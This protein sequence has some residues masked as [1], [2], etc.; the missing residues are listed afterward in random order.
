ML[1]SLEIKNF[2]TF[3][4]LA[5]E[6]LGRV[7]LIVGKNGVGKTTLLEA[8]RLYGA[9]WPLDTI[10]SILHSRNELLASDDGKA[11][12]L[13]HSLFHGRAADAG[14]TF[15]IGECG[16]RKSLPDFCGTAGVVAEPDGA[17]KTM[18]NMSYV[19]PLQQAL[20]MKVA[21]REF[22]LEADRSGGYAIR[23][24]SPKPPEWL[25]EPPS[26]PALGVG[27]NTLASWWDAISLTESE[28]HIL[29]AM[30]VIARL[31]GVAFVGDPRN[32]TSR[33]ARVRVA[34][35]DEP[36]PL[37]ILGD[38]VVR[39]FQIAVAIE[40]STK[41]A[42]SVRE[43]DPKLTNIFPLLLIDEI[44]SGVHHTLHADLWR[45]ILQTARR[46]DV[47]VFAT[48]HSQD[49]LRGFA[50]AVAEDEEADGQVI[51]LEQ[52]KG[53]EATRAVLFDR[54]DLPI[55]LRDSIEV[56]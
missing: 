41:H 32:R 18:A 52:L 24:G 55:V 53:Q 4:H 50:E 34:S 14:D 38:G 51:R 30:Q 40:C 21:G 3:S 45:F 26:L 49:C 19:R 31:E 29:E 39:M 15:T 33:I 8:L 17:F 2:R 47:Q 44:E 12:L 48:T 6:R 35:T 28:R 54:T 23:S 43:A 16:I 22:T 42:A 25:P 9:L 20:Q 1:K 27:E 46:L 7:N 36:V 37:A 5:I 10:E 13:L 11:L 56:R